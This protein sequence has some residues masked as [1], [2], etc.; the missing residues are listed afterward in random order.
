MTR[1][2][3]LGPLLVALAF[4][5]FSSPA[6]TGGSA[7]ATLYIQE[8]P[9]GPVGAA[10]ALEGGCTPPLVPVPPPLAVLQ[11]AELFHDADGDGLLDPGDMISYTAEITG[12]ALNSLQDL[13]LIVLFSPELVPEALPEGWKRLD[14]GRIP[15]LAVHLP[16]L[17]IGDR[18]RVGFA[19]RFVG[20]EGSPPTLFIEGIVYS[21]G[22]AM[23]ADDPATEIFLDPAA[24]ATREVAGGVGS[25]FPGVPVFSKKATVAS[26]FPSLRVGSVG[27]TV[28]FEVVYI[29]TSLEREVELWDLVPAPLQ[30]I[31]DSLEPKVDL[32]ELGGLTFLRT[33]F[34]DV[35]PGV[36]VRLEYAAVIGDPAS[37]P[38]V[39]T[40]A[41]A[42]TE[43]GVYF[44]DDPD[45]P[46]GGDPTAVLFPW[47]KVEEPITSWDVI[48]RNGGCSIPVMLYPQ[49]GKETLRWTLCGPA[50]VGEF[51]PGT[52]RFWILQVPMR[53]LPKRT[54]FDFLLSYIPQW[55][56][57]EIYMP[58]VYG[59]P[60]FSTL[61]EGMG[62]LGEL[63]EGFC[64]ELYLPVVAEPPAGI[65]PYLAGVITD[66][67]I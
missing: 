47:R 7:S 1:T 16:S 48:S 35:F 21:P 29:P 56:R 67:D 31:V 57:G 42:V 54:S 62:S 28:E 44:S 49:N 63:G 24:V 6:N 27:D 19:A 17:R 9:E 25:L 66:E 5:P 59:A 15:A 13:Y 10:G 36:P 55:S 40:H 14:L 53:Q 3:G 46:E 50:G 11:T 64:G 18:A 45:S 4:L 8:G 41:M 52:L 60:I 51:R 2:L 12:F 37:V 26:S 43:T 23:A 61:A 58:A 38:F 30:V 39:A 32:I 65:P 33:R 34:R 20:D 22:F